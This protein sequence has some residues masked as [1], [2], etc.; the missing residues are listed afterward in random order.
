M[1]R[2]PNFYETTFQCDLTVWHSDVKW[3]FQIFFTGSNM[4]GYKQVVLR[5]LLLNYSRMYSHMLSR[6]HTTNARD[7]VALE[8]IGF[9]LDIGSTVSRAFFVS[10]RIIIDL[11][12]HLNPLLAGISHA[13]PLNCPLFDILFR[14]L[15]F[16]RSSGVK[17]GFGYIYFFP[18][19]K[20]IL[21]PKVTRNVV[22][23]INRWAN[24]RTNI[25]T[26][27]QHLRVTWTY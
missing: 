6:T 2:T 26:S 24:T 27:I 1:L 11:G 19:I 22:E 16:Y 18:V 13:L 14:S 12:N 10:S 4:P 5:S 9:R 3:C 25:Q 23:T 21:C 7:C 20:K 15:H 8:K 17:I